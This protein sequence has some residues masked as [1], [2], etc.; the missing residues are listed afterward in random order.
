M[1]EPFGAAFGSEPTQSPENTLK[2]SE[3]DQLNINWKEYSADTA[4]YRKDTD[5]HDA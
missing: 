5:D 4:T 2:Y 1:N 3:D